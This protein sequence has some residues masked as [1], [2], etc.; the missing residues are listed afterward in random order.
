MPSN[1]QQ[2]S[3]TIQKNLSQKNKNVTAI[4]LNLCSSCQ[5]ENRPTAKYC[6]FCGSIM[7]EAAKPVPAAAPS[8]AQAASAD[9][10]GKPQPA[11]YI[12]LEAI[13]QELGKQKN[14][15]KI[16][17]ERIKRGIGGVQ[18]AS[19]FMFRGNTGTGK[20]LVA[21]SFVSE[22]KTER[23]LESD[24]I[25]QISAK[26]LSRQYKDEF[27]IE[28]FLADNKPAALVIDEAHEDTAFLHELLLGLSKSSPHRICILLGLREPLEE[29]FK[30]NPEDNRR[31][32][33]FF[34]FPDQTGEELALILEKQLREYGFTYEPALADLFAGCIQERKHDPQCAYKNGWLIEKDIV[35]AILKSQAERIGALS[36]L[37]DE[38]FKKIF[39]E[40]LPLKTK[41]RSV[42]EILAELDGMIGLAD[43]KKAVRDIANK[44]QIQKEIEEKD[45]T[46]A[47]GEGNNIV[48]T[49]NP[50][51]GKTTIVR[52]LG[53]LF[54]AV[55]LLPSDKVV[56]TDGNGL[57]GS[58][59]GQS[60]DNVNA[61]CEEAMGGILFVDEAYTLANE[62]G[63]MDS[64]AE[65]AAVTL[66]KH[67]EDDRTKFVGV[68]AG[69]PDEMKNF[70][71]KI[72]PGMRRRFKHFIHLPDYTA[73][74]L[75]QIFDQMTAKAGYSLTEEALAA[76]HEAI[77]LMHQKKSKTFGNAGEI[78]VFFER[79]T[80]KQ[81]SRL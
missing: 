63:A 11:D 38:D 78:R 52:T 41:K 81:S 23:C 72:N 9:A 58:Y 34:D 46:R 27:A 61:K 48:I 6:R 60:K 7:P 10:S 68:A 30:K 22:L 44:I 55:G 49:G 54:K 36:S 40:D 32:N 73:E 13:R 2:E 26:A 17:R 77:Y 56:E 65:E 42:D 50:G 80:S 21:S 12:G 71:D 76:S 15:I 31:V 18:G 67:L 25:T 33:N 35:P 45:G 74:E 16:Q 59:L 4:D 5:K 1:N 53:A 29:F 51:T 24:R 70:L 69:Y 62:R 19:I 3:D 57:K 20:T 8:T 28:T 39:E 37:T 79:T 64:F 14:L 75:C 47:S 66:M 43:V